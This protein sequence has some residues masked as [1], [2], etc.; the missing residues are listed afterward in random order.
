MDIN[1]IVRFFNKDKNLKR[2]FDS[3]FNNNRNELFR[4]LKNKSKDQLVIYPCTNSGY[5]VGES[6]KYCSCW[7]NWFK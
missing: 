7:R 5:G 4:S 3:V 2:I 1:A 6:G